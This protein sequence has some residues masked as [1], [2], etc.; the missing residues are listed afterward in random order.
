MCVFSASVASLV[1]STTPIVDA[2]ILLQTPQVRSAMLKR[3]FEQFAE[4]GDHASTSPR[5]RHSSVAYRGVQDSASM[6]RTVS[7]L[8]H[9]S[10]LME[11]VLISCAVR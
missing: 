5:G 3:L 8:Q 9:L 2:V 6:A 7:M 11:A 1:I 4:D 10:T